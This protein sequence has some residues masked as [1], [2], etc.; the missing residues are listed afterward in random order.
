MKKAAERA[1]KQLPLSSS[2]DGAHLA[3]QQKT[4][5]TSKQQQEE[6]PRS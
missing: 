5:K 3:Q 2:S 1:V 6:G 4:P